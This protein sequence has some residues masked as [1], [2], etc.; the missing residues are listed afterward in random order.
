[1]KNIFK[2]FTSILLCIT[3]LFTITSCSSKEKTKEKIDIEISKEATSLSSIENDIE[4]IAYKYSPD[5]ILTNATIVYN[6]NDEVNSQKGVIY[7]TYCKNDPD[8]KHGITTTVKYDMAKKTAI[9]VSYEKGKGQFKDDALKPITDQTKKI[10]FSSIFDLIKADN[11]MGN[12]LKGKN[13]Q[14]TIDFNYNGFV[15]SI[16]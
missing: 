2:V 5:S 15:P 10:L 9:E 11:S 8:E 4:K 3:L 6:G 14:L 13:I 7:Y 16:I 12:K 1:M